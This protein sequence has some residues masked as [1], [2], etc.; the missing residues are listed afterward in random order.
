MGLN[1][2]K[3][4]NDLGVCYFRTSLFSILKP[5]RHVLE[6]VNIIPNLISGGQILSAENS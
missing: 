4:W 2:K 3:T 6:S 5:K 1:F